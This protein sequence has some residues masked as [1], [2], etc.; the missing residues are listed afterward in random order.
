MKNIYILPLILFIISCGNEKVIKK[1][2]IT[3]E[4]SRNFI[5]INNYDKLGNIVETIHLNPDSSERS[6]I[7]FEYTYDSNNNIIQLYKPDSNR[8]SPK[9]ER[10]IYNYDSNNNL[11][12]EYIHE[13]YRV[14]EPYLGEHQEKRQYKYDSN[15]NLIEEI[16]TPI[17]WDIK[18]GK[19]L[20]IHPSQ[21]E[22]LSSGKGIRNVWKTIYE[23][24][25]YDNMIKKSFYNK[26]Y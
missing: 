1:E 17:N 8:F 13:D 23:Y 2:I 15:D 4:G 10:K 5:K 12:E 20:D 14:F 25:K 3:L 11:I 7:F 24:D 22:Y 21:L 19:N 6:R 9:G 16:Y 26:D 18:S